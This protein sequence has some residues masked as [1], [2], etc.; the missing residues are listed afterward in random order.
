MTR[1][2][3]FEGR[4]RH[5]V[6]VASANL[7]DLG[8]NEQDRLSL[9]EPGFERSRSFYPK[10]YSLPSIADGRATSRRSRRGIE[11]DLNEAVFSWLSAGNPTGAALFWLAALAQWPVY[12]LPLLLGGLWLFGARA[13][14]EATMVACVVAAL[15]MI[16][17]HLASDLIDHPRPFMMGLAKNLLDHAADSSFPSDHATL[18]FALA[19]S[20]ALWRP[21]RMPTLG[22]LLAIV[23]LGVGWA[24][25]ALG[26]HF[27]FDVVGAAAIGI[28]AA[29]VVLASPFRKP[30][31]GLTAVGEAIGGFIGLPHRRD[32]RVATGSAGGD[33]HP[34]G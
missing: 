14:R 8:A 15:A 21:H 32:D 30:L 16:L 20:F 13:T 19:A 23:G 17:A 3:P 26:V 9:D 29:I 31:A 1:T 10:S 33:A 18:F 5:P 6:S 28:A 11:T 4:R 22:A 7:G 24:R 27:P 12:G 34:A 25:V 2:R